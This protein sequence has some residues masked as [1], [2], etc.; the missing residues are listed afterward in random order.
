MASGLSRSLCEKVGLGFVDHATFDLTAA[1]NAP[2]TLV[3]QNAG[4]DLYLLNAA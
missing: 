3:V 1:A 4:R 2:E